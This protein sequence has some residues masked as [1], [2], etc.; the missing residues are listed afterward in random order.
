MLFRSLLL[1]NVDP[2]NGT[3]LWLLPPDGEAKVWLSNGATNWEAEFSPDGRTIAYSS[4]TSGRFEVYVQSRD[5]SADRVQASAAG[6]TAPAWSPNGKQL[7]F[8]QGNVIMETTIGSTGGLSA[9]APVQ[10]FDGGWTLP[11]WYPFD[12]MPD[13]QHFAMIQQPREVV[14]TRIDVVLNWF[15]V[16]KEAL[17]E[18]K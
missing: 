3:E 1:M 6:G 4:N 13:G 2:K 8:R 9:T 16:L 5:N 18:P 14:Q 15:P 10:V 17:G 11:Q 12:V 7:L